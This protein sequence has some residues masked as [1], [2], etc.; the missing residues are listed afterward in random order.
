M[1]LSLIICYHLFTRFQSSSIC[2]NFTAVFNRL[3]I[4]NVKSCFII[5][6]TAVCVLLL[7]KGG[8]CSAVAR[9]ERGGGGVWEVVAGQLDLTDVDVLFSFP[10]KSF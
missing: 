9:G 8:K 3:F 6:V 4:R 10:S 7:L 2:V 5:F 1:S